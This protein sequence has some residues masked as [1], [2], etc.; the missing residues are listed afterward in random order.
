MAQLSQQTSA[1]AVDTSLRAALPATVLQSIWAA[2]GSEIFITT[3]VVMSFFMIRTLT[4][5][6]DEKPQQQAPVKQQMKDAEELPQHQPT[7]CLDAFGKKVLAVLATNDFPA[8]VAAFREAGDQL[9]Q[10]RRATALLSQAF[11]A[12]SAPRQ[13]SWAMEL[14]DVTKDHIE[15]TR[16]AYHALVTCLSYHGDADSAESIIRDMVMEN[17]MP[18]AATYSALIRG[19]LA[20]GNLERG[21]QVLGKMRLQGLKPEL[22][23]FHVILEACAQRQMSTLADQIVSD[24]LAEGLKPTSTTLAILVRLYGKCGDLAAALSTFESFPAKYDIKVD[25]QVY[26]SLISVCV[27]DSDMQKAFAVYE[28]MAFAGL[29][30]DA[31]TYKA[32]LSGSLQDGDLDSAARLIDDAFFNGCAGLLSREPLELFLLQAVRR[33]RGRELAVPALEQAQNAGVFVSERIVNNV[34]RHRQ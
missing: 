29:R 18:D 17:V 4:Q 3:L 11:K 33:G 24:A 10:Q 26:A 16:P 13:A 23:L 27:A 32:L 9:S 28:Q 6:P 12:A 21:L 1:L 8:V 5:C 22:Q 19:Q 7:N 25:A 30:A 2:A 20:R 34:L 31:P 14:Y 15:Y